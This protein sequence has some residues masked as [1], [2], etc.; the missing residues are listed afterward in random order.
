MVWGRQCVEKR[1]AG[2][3]DLVVLDDK[4][5]P[6]SINNKE[7]GLCQ[8]QPFDLH[9]VCVVKVTGVVALLKPVGACLCNKGCNDTLGIRDFSVVLFA[10]QHLGSSFHRGPPPVQAESSNNHTGEGE[11]EGGD[12]G[13]GEGGGEG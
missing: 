5:R 1:N 2:C 8:L 6:A 12:E 3:N 4:D 11:G 9:R 13:E 7:G 10:I